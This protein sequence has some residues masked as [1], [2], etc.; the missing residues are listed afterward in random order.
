MHTPLDK[1]LI[2][3]ISHFASL[4]HIA[5]LFPTC[6]RVFSDKTYHGLVNHSQIIS[7][8]K[9]EDTAIFINKVKT[10]WKILNVKGRGTDVRL[11]DPLEA[12]ICSPDDCYS[13]TLLRF[14]DMAL[15]M[16]CKKC[17][18]VKQLSNDTAKSIHHTCNGTVEECKHLLATSHDYVLLGMFTNDHLEKNLEN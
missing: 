12:P 6:L 9:S 13:Y 16:C 2:V 17:K 7:V 11:N 1:F 4:F 5:T 3:N 8:L 10:W 14:G 18:R 15:E